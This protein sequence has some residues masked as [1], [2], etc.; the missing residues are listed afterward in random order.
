MKGSI[1]SE[2][3]MIALAQNIALLL[4]PVDTIVLKGDLGTGKTV[5]ARGIITACVP[6]TVEVLSPT[7]TLLQQY[8]SADC[9]LWHYDLYRLESAAELEE[10]GIEEAWSQ[11]LVLVEWPEILGTRLPTSYLEVQLSIAAD[12]ETRD[13]VLQGHGR[14][15]SLLLANPEI[16]S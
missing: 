1:Q 8:Q 11:G 4:E 7:F 13:I 6:G 2:Q 10:L 16:L 9:Q 5:F 3:E 12:G 14:W 15:A